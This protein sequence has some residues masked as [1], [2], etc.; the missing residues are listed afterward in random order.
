MSF[1]A[2]GQKHLP[3]PVWEVSKTQHTLF[4]GPDLIGAVLCESKG[5]KIEANQK[6]SAA[7]G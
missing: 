4:R 3:P 6:T 1:Q 5:L 7:K 2:S